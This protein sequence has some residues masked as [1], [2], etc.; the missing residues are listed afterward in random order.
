V[1]PVLFLVTST[2][3]QDPGT[4][5]SL[6]LY[7]GFYERIATFKRRW[8]G[9]FPRESRRAELGRAV[10]DPTIDNIFRQKHSLV[11]VVETVAMNCHASIEIVGLVSDLHSRRRPNDDGMRNHSRRYQD[12]ILAAG[13]DRY[14]LPGCDTTYSERRKIKHGRM[15][16]KNMHH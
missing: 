5:A 15:N 4:R 10:T 16:V 11:G 2:T 12:Q 1:A 8:N 3:G 6:A 7:D 14:V 13:R 9:W